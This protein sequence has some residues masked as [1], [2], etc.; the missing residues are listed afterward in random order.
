MDKL[1]EAIEKAL[2]ANHR[3]VLDHHYIIH[4]GKVVIVDDRNRVSETI[5]SKTIDG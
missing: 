3:F 5:E 1:I 2:Q 4:D